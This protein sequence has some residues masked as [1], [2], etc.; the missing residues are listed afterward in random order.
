MLG[1]ILLPLANAAFAGLAFYSV[2]QDAHHHSWLPW[3]VLVLAAFYLGLFRLPQ[4]AL[5]S[6]I[7]LSIAV[8]FLTIA[9]PLKASGAWITVS[10]LVE[11]TALI[12][13]ATRLGGE[14]A[15][16]ARGTLRWLGLGSLGLGFFGVCFHV[17]DVIGSDPVPLWNSCT[18]TALTAVAAYGATA[19][20]AVRHRSEED[21]WEGVAH[22][23]VWLMGAT[24]MLLSL[25]ELVFSWEEA[26]HR[27][28]AT[29]GFGKAL[30]ALAI[31]AGMIA[32]SLRIE[33]LHEEESFWMACA[34]ASTVAF[35]VVAVLTGVREVSALFAPAPNAWSA[36]AA[37]QQSLAISGFL[38]FYGAALLA[39]GF[40]RRSS[41]LRWQALALLLFTICKAFL[42]D[43]R[44]L[45]Q[46]YRVASLLALGALLLAVSFAYQKDW[47]NLRD[48]DK[49]SEV[50]R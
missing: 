19:W 7:H 43:L 41:F 23:V 48:D 39:V 3:M 38:M 28:F 16:H 44:N 15:A 40:W 42:Y 36:D 14:T 49:H 35:N 5:A 20:L 27:A 9:I 34:A 26:V 47:L 1:E 30:L 32:A 29:G 22:T 2:L 37:L 4:T 31:L 24:A 46:G 11:G 17:F 33:V 18:G 6:A 13:V 10:W 21:P 25:R 50:T 12:W 8:V 45:S